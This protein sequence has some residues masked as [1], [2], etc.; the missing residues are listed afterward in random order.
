MRETEGKNT[1]A[2]GEGLSSHIGLVFRRSQ[3]YI[4]IWV[5]GIGGDC[6]VP[7]GD[8]Y[9]KGQSQRRNRIYGGN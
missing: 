8:V 9:V 1:K 6:R 7:G 5:S 4:E 3:A 2:T